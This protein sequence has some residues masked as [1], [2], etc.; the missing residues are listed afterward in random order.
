MCEFELSGHFY[1]EP[2]V[3]GQLNVV[4]VG[5]NDFG[6]FTVLNQ[7]N[8]VVDKTDFISIKDGVRVDYEM[9]YNNHG[10][11]RIYP[12]LMSDEKLL[13]DTERHEIRVKEETNK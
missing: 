10:R 5:E 1:L 7:D 8:K 3:N 13:Y 12:S 9:E 6:E 2:V 4:S 11:F